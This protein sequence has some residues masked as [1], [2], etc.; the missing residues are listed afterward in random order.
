MSINWKAFYA[1]GGWNGQE[2]P[3]FY[4]EEDE[5][6]EQIIECKL[7]EGNKMVIN[8]ADEKMTCPD[9]DGMGYIKI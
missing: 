2:P 5:D 7:C 9:C 4:E 3:D 8:E 6:E 1:N